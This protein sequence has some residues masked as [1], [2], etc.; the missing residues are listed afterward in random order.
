M[1][2]LATLKILQKIPRFGSTVQMT[3]KI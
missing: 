3:S 2:I 1:L